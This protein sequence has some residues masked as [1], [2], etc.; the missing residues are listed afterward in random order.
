MEPT[1]PKSSSLI[2]EISGKSVE[3][4]SGRPNLVLEVGHGGAST[5][6]YAQT[7]EYLK[8]KNAN[9]LGIDIA[10]GAQTLAQISI[11]DK[12]WAAVESA[13]ISSLEGQINSKADEVWLRNFSITTQLMKTLPKDGKELQKWLMKC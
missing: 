13:E 9:Y 5:I 11:K 2:I 1:E 10:P 8:T 6:M 3:F 12:P 7:E 4:Q